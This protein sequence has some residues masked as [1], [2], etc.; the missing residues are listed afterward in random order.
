M[1][2]PVKYLYLLENTDR[3]QKIIYE[4]AYFHQFNLR[5]GFFKHAY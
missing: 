1:V 2:G 3:K 5:I 4:V